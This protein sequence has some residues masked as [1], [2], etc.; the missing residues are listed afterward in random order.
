LT[1][2][3]AA[4]NFLVVADGDLDRVQGDLRWLVGAG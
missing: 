1:C 4:R 2:W 3:M